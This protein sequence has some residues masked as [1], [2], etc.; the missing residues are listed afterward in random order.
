MGWNDRPGLVLRG[1]GAGD[2]SLPRSESWGTPHLC[3]GSLLPALPAAALWEMGVG[4]AA[5]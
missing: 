1:R 4:G 5:S 3:S 2:P